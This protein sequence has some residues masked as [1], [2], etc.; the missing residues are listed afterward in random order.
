MSALNSD[1]GLSQNVLWSLALLSFYLLLSP[2]SPLSYFLFCF[3]AV[4]ITFSLWVSLSRSLIFFWFFME[5][6]FL[7]LEGMRKFSLCSTAYQKSWM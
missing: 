7:S 1:G 6:F 2:I 4:D 5:L 3:N